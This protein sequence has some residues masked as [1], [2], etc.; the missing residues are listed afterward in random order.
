ML[1]SGKSNIFS[2]S[3]LKVA[4]WEVRLPDGVHL[5]EF[6]HGTTTGRRTARVDGREVMRKDWMFKLVGTEQF[7]I[8]SS[9]G[10]KANCLIKIEPVGGFSYQYSLEVNG[11][12]YKVWDKKNC[13]S[14]HS[15]V[16]KIEC[17][18][19]FVFS[20]KSIQQYHFLLRSEIL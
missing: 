8:N 1:K 14:Y 19:P 6:E 7:A 15:T 2:L 16:V 18:I 13:C 12:P 4:A 17:I 20:T 10:K 3:F 5:I 9:K 11:K